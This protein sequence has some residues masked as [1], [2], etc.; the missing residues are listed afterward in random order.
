MPHK[1]IFQTL[2]VFIILLL[3]PTL[4]TACP[5][6]SD[7]AATGSEP[8]AADLADCLLLAQFDIET[9]RGPVVGSIY[10][11]PESDLRLVAAAEEALT[12]SGRALAGLGALGS[13]P[14]DLYISP[15]SYSF[16]TEDDD[17]TLAA[18]QIGARP[19]PDVA[20]KCIMA[21]FPTVRMDEIK[22]TIAHE[23]FHCVQFK[24][25]SSSRTSAGADW[26]V[27]GTAEWFA[28]LVYQ[29]T[30]LSDGWVSG[31][32]ADSAR[33]PVTQMPYTSVVF[34]WWMGQNMGPESIVGLMRAMEGAGGSQEDTLA[35]V[36]SETE[37]LQF[38]TDYLE[39]NIVQPGG[40]AAAS[41]PLHEDIRDI[42]EDTDITLEAGRFVAHRTL[43]KFACGSWTTTVNDT[44]GANKALRLPDGDWEDLPDEFSSESEARIE[45]LFAGAGTDAD[46]FRLEFKAEKTPCAPCQAPEISDGPEA[47]LIGEWR[48][49]SGGM[50]AKIGQMLNEGSALSGVDYPDIDGLLILRRDGTFSLSANDDGSMELSTERG[51]FSARMSISMEK[52]GTWSI[53]GDDLV[54]C[55]RPIKSIEIDET[56]TD[57]DGLSQRITENQFRGP[58]LSYEETRQFTCNEG[59]LQ[60]I[61]R[62]FFAPT[63]EW[64]YEK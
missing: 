18:A 39:G 4:S 17:E 51:T 21:A 31:F 11:L 40:R 28:S 58:K 25:F 3:F 61:Q 19:T 57:P 52:E 34:F 38:V 10:G 49:A 9:G 41:T 33:V 53:N 5:S 64:V 8:S 56:V 23:F 20:R 7:L 60:I 42:D 15:T 30:S 16:E 1:N 27:E 2:A 48:L 47:C 24:E 45:F 13:D 35:S 55:Y 22:F 14:V 50:G 43:L 36:V 62:A 12:R 63:I 44:K 59:V 37:F 46:G 54:Q 6:A 32:D 26:W 29:G